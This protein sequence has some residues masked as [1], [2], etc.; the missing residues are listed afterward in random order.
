MSVDVDDAWSQHEPAGVDALAGRPE[1]GAD[2]GDAAAID[3]GPARSG[4]TTKAVD[5]DGVVDDEVVHL[6]RDY[7][8]SPS[9]CS[10][11]LLI[12]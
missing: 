11:R 5:D 3:G 9:R 4:G 10:S 12:S 2:R 1:I 6:G 7:F 8:L